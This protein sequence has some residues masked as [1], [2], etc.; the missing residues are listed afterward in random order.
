VTAFR[1]R[2]AE[3]AVEIVLRHLDATMAALERL[4]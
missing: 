3:E 2:R 1:R 4:A